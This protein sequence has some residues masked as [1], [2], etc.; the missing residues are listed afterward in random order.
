MSWVLTAAPEGG[1][2]AHTTSTLALADLTG[3]DAG[4]KGFTWTHIVLNYA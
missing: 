3:P 1:T 4:L 2:Y